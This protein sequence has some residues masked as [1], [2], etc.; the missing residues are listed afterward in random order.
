MR[1]LESHMYIMLSENENVADRCKDLVF[2]DLGLQSRLAS[3]RFSFET[4]LLFS[5]SFDSVR[6]NRFLKFLTPLE[7]CLLAGIA[8][9]SSPLQ[10]ETASDISC[11]VTRG[12]CARSLGDIIM[13][14][15]EQFITALSSL[16][17]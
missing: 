1:G 7:F 15:S 17:L 11:C 14:G 10:E 2:K 12:D 4:L 8:A 5:L 9:I 6:D 16:G 13:V 3:P